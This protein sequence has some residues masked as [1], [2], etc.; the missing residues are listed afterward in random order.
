M[1]SVRTITVRSQIAVA[2]NIIIHSAN[3]GRL[4]GR[5][6]IVVMVVKAVVARENSS[7]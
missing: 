6:W 7:F 5:G 4:K 1:E 2:R 3:H